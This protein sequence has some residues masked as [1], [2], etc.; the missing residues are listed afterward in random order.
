VGV[1]AERKRA[2]VSGGELAYLDVGEGPAVLLLHGFPTSSFLWRR[3]VWL[4]SQEL[5]V[6]APDLLGYGESEK[7]PHADLSLPAQ[8]GYLRELLAGLGVGEVA[9]VGHHLGAALALALAAGGEPRVRALVLLDGVCLEARPLQGMDEVLPLLGGS[10]GPGTPGPAGEAGV[11]PGGPVAAV[12]AGAPAAGVR[13]GRPEEAVRAILERGTR[14][15]RLDERSL[16]GYV[17]PWRVEPGALG[18]AARA[19][20][21]GP[22]VPEERELAA[23]EVPTLV[24]WGEEDPFVPARLAERLGEL[25]PDATVALLPGCAHLVTEDAPE[26]VGLLLHQY[27]RARYLGRGHGHRAGGPVPVQLGRPPRLGAWGP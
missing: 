21:D 6:L 2:R 10:R 19:V 14:R 22:G 18:R 4:L 26:T 1:G 24:V 20:A 27:L 25:L 13:A 5:R 8:A 15:H 11:R 3:E 12:R 17:S 7:P 9:V 16:D 23:L